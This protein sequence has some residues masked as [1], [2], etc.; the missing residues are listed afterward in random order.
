MPILLYLPLHLLTILYLIL[1]CLL[2]FFWCIDEFFFQS[3]RVVVSTL[4]TFTTVYM[5]RDQR[6]CK[7]V[8]ALDRHKLVPVF[9]WHLSGCNFCIDVSWYLFLN[10]FVMYTFFAKW[11]AYTR[12]YILAI[13]S[14]MHHVSTSKKNWWIAF[15]WMQIWKTYWAVLL[16]SLSHTLMIIFHC[17][18][19]AT[20]TG[21]TVEEITFTT[22]SANATLRAVENSLF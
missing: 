9:F 19:Q 4:F 14:L 21:V 5:K 15:C 3:G 1:L 12:H 17:K 7:A 22:N 20:T 2:N 18:T 11:A 10:C 13:A 6:L 8:I 16:G